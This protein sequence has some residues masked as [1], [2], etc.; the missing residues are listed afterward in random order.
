VE[1]RVVEY[2]EAVFEGYDLQVQRQSA[3]ARHENLVIEFPGREEGP[4]VLFES[5]MDT[6]PADDWIDRAFV[7][8]VEG[9]T[10]FGRGACDDK[11]PLVAMVLALLD[12]V[13]SGERPPQRLV[14]V[15]AGDEEY[16]QTGIRHYVDEPCPA[17]RL[18][19]FGEPTGNTPVIQHKGAVRWEITAHGR[20][21]HT[22]Q[23]ERGRNAIY[24]MAGVVQ[25]I[26]EYQDSIQ[27]LAPNPLLTGPRITVSMIQGGNAPN[28]VPDRCTAVVD[29][30]IMP[31]L[32]PMAEYRKATEHL[33]SLGADISHQE[34]KVVLPPLSTDPGHAAVAVIAELC[35]SVLGRPVDPEGAPYGTDASRMPDGVPAVVI[36]PG[37]IQY[38]H[39]VDEQIRVDELLQGA[40]IYRRCMLTDWAAPRATP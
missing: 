27:D 30:R 34:P 18:G 26:R 3:G 39:V 14:L 11:G 12:V 23:S 28:I 33:A 22:S 20:S 6:V 29:Y 31:G 35:R 9:G 2:L 19:V 38:A 4:A 15:A 25:A 40:E 32:D 36:G 8:R 5:H 16:G 1:R 37:D 21:A 7:P 24:E 17:L 13:E 10:V